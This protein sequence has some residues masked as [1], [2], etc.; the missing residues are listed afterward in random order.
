MHITVSNH[1]ASNFTYIVYYFYNH[2]DEKDET[3]IVN[4]D[5]QEWQI[6]NGLVSAL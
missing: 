1:L 5:K 3:M 6:E 4:A 2:E